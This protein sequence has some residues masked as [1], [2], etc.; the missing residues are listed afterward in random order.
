MTI[1]TSSIEQVIPG[2][3]SMAQP[4]SARPAKRRRFTFLRNAK[5]ATGLVIFGI[6][7]LFAIIGPWI[8]P[9]DPD[10][11]GNALV[12]V[13]SGAVKAPG[14]TAAPAPTCQK[15]VVKS[16]LT[17]ARLPPRPRGDVSR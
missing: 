3:G 9:Y 10:A 1:P 14:V 8:A 13:P 5:A 16:S 15:S 2:Q 7:L 12:K 11:R 4:V 6:Y 17:A